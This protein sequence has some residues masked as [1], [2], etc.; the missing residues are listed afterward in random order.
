MHANNW[1]QRGVELLTTIPYDCTAS[2]AA[3]ALTTVDKY[4]EEGESLKL[5]TFNNEPDLNKLIMLTTTETSTL[6]T[7]VA[8]RIDDMRRL[9]VSRR[10]ALQKMVLREIRKPPVQVVSPEKLSSANDDNRCAAAST[11]KNLIPAS[12]AKTY[13][14]IRDTYSLMF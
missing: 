12:P 8:E 13:T 5:D 6:L 7:Q 14:D 2:Y 1:C 3:N 11:N 9:S 4:I 10:D